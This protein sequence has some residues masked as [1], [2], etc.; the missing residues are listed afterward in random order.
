VRASN[1]LGE[2]LPY[3][4]IDSTT[5]VTSSSPTIRDTS[6]PGATFFAS[7]IPSI[8]AKWGACMPNQPMNWSSLKTITSTDPS[9]SPVCS[10]LRLKYRS[11]RWT[12]VARGARRI[13]S[14][15]PEGS[16]S[17]PGRKPVV[18]DDRR[19]QVRASRPLL[20][21]LRQDAEG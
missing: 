11:R 2:R 10:P 21:R 15:L 13:L 7:T 14:I 16:S 5:L 6:F 3:E 17:V 18:G 20:R 9:R 8:A 1:D 19:Q 12:S 4:P